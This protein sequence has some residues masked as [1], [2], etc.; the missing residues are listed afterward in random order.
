[1]FP[2]DMG[3]N[4][5]RSSG[6]DGSDEPQVIS[7]RV[8]LLSGRLIGAFPDL[9]LDQG[10]QLLQKLQQILQTISEFI[11][12]VAGKTSIDEKILE[13]FDPPV[14]LMVTLLTKTGA[15]TRLARRSEVGDFLGLPMGIPLDPL[16]A[17]SILLM[18]TLF[19]R[20]TPS[21]AVRRVRRA[22]CLPWCFTCPSC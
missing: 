8:C 7:T 22:P 11:S 5:Q 1:M 17:K 6:S 10:I 16:V 20:R 15:L 4:H 9:K 14:R 13:F 2:A 12:K 3:R 18:P 21:P 19:L